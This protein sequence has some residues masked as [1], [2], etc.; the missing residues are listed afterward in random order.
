M[1]KILNIIV[2]A[3]ALT[4]CFACNNEWEDEQFAHYVGFKAPI[5]SEGCT[6]VYL[7]LRSAAEIAEKGPV[8]YKLPLVVSGSTPH[9]GDLK[10]KVEL[11]LDSLEQ[12]NLKN[13]GFNR[14]DIWWHPVPG[15]DTDLNLTDD[16]Y[17][18]KYADWL[19][20]TP[21][22]SNGERAFTLPSEVIIPSGKSI[23]LVPITFNFKEELGWDWTKRYILPLKVAENQPGYTANTRKHYNNALLNIIP[24]NDYSGSYGASTMLGYSAD[25]NGNFTDEMLSLAPLTMSD[26]IFYAV[27]ENTAFFYPG[28]IDHTYK[29]RAD[30]K[31][32]VTFEQGGALSFRAENPDLDFQIVGPATYERPE[33][34]DDN[35]PYLLYKY[36]IL[37]FTYDFTDRTGAVPTRYRF[38][39]AMTMQRAVNTQI[40]DE[41]QAI[42][43]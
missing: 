5:N 33:R 39:G 1:N 14:K 11:D 41:D 26:K 27:D 8:T 38:K 25:D 6:S 15:V 43:W 35:K 32:Y 34:V 31:V 16:D 29:Q 13:I 12:L 20:K 17:N 28:I 7:K 10:V 9:S 3:A 37:Q 22:N 30:Y 21:V 23:E 24:F 4:F 18:V 19:V 36:V 42:Q 40:P 2:A